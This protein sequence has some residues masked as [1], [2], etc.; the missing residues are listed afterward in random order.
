MKKQILVFGLI[1][2]WCLFTSHADLTNGAVGSA[3]SV[4]CG[5][6][7]AEGELLVKFKG[8][9]KGDGAK[10][11]KEEFKHTVKRDLMHVG[12]S[13]VK[14]PAGITV[15]VALPK[16]KKHP[17]VLG[18]EANIILR[19]CGPVVPN[20]PMY[21]QQWGL[22]AICA[23]YAWEVATGSTN[24]VVAV[25]DSGINYNHEDLAANMWR[26][27]WEIPGNGI[28][29][30]GNGH[31][32][33]VYGVDFVNDDGDPMDE[34][35]SEGIYHGTGIA[36]II[37]AVGQ[38]GIG[39]C[40]LNWDVRLMA[41]RFIRT[42]GLGEAY[43]VASS[44]DYIVEMKQR[45]VNVKAVNMSFG[46]TSSSCGILYPNCLIDGI[47]AL[48]A[49]GIIAV[50]G[51]GN[52]SVDVEQ[53][54]FYP[55]CYGHPNIISVAASTGY[56]ALADFSNWGVVSVDLAAPGTGILMASGPGPTDYRQSSGTSYATPYVAGTVALLAAAYPEATVAQ[57]KAGI[58]DSVDVLSALQG[59]VLTGGQ[60]NIG[61]A[62]LNLK[63]NQAPVLVLQPQNMTV[64]PGGNVMVRASFGGTP[65][66]RYQWYQGDSALA[67]PTNTLLTLTN[68]T[69]EL[70][71]RVQATNAFGQEDSSPVGIGL[72]GVRVP[73]VAWGANNYGQCDV[74]WDLTNVAA[75]AGGRWHSLALRTD[76]TL[77][78]WGGNEYGE[79]DVPTGLSNIVAM[80]AGAYHN[81][82]LGTNGTVAAWGDNY[83]GQVDVPTNLTDVVAVS[84]GQYHNL[85]MKQNGEVV[86]WGL[87]DSSQS[88]VPSGLTN[89]Q[90]V[91]AGYSHS[92]ALLSNGTVVAWGLDRG[93]EV[94]PSGLEGI[95]SVVA[96]TAAS[97]ALKS[98]GT[99]AVWGAND[100][101]QLNVPAGLSNVVAIAGYSTFVA[102]KEDG[103][104][105][106]WGAGMT[107]LGSGQDWGQGIVPSSLRNVNS[108]A[109]NGRHCMALVRTGPVILCVSNK[110]VYEGTAWEFDPPTAF[111][112]CTGSSLPVTILST[113]TNGVSSQIITRTWVATNQCNALFATCSQSVTVLGLAPA[114]TAQPQSQT[115][116]VGQDAP[117]LVTATGWPPLSFQWWF[118]GSTIADATDR[119]Y[120]RTSAQVTDAG[121]YF[122]VVTNSY[123][124]ITSA[125][126]VLAISTAVFAPAIATQPQSQTVEV[127]QDAPFSVTATGLGPLSFQ[128]RFNG[129]AIAG[130]TASAYTRTNAQPAD[131]GT[132]LVVVTN[133]YGGATSAPATLTVV[134]G[135]ALSF[136]GGDRVIINNAPAL[137]PA[138][139]TV[140]TWV[141]FG[142]LVTGS[143][144]FLLCK[145]GD[146]TSG[147]YRLWQGES[148]I[149]FSIGEFWNG[150]G[151]SRSVALI[152]NRWY[153]MAGSYDGAMM[154]LYLDGTLISSN[155]VGSISVGNDSPLYLSFDDVLGYPYSLLGKMDEVRIWDYARTENEIRSTM[156][157]SLAGNEPGL[158]GYWNFNEPLSSQVVLDRST[159]GSSGQL[160]STMAVDGDDPTR[161]MQDIFAP[162]VVVDFLAGPT[163]G[164]APL[165]V[166]FT[167]LCSGATNYEWD[168][169]DGNASTNEHPINLYTNAD[170]Y[171]V[172]LTAIGSGGTNSL[173][174]SDYIVVLEPQLPVINSAWWDYANLMVFWGTGGYPGS[175]YCV[176]AS[177]NVA[178]PMTNWLPVMTNTFEVDGSFRVTNAVDTNQPAQFFRVR[179]P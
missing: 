36:S 157:G 119:A 127:G 83:Y 7:Y 112:G 132:Y 120:T 11:V 32:D 80:S 23:P 22:A 90:A 70:W 140:E 28:D 74:P 48:G 162:A 1:A 39:V 134:S 100:Y 156:Y 163:N 75:V 99:V 164:L 9:P 88:T 18:A 57:L 126:A 8:G 155:M 161:V 72:Q 66:L 111:D 93:A 76:G 43:D 109:I 106:A 81:L 17:D 52:S 35:V 165:T 20:D 42:D 101:G 71:V 50:A 12:W 46:S 117:F 135:W 16:Y 138:Q 142:A 64:L 176:L 73:V 167:N 95:V 146:R 2:C 14:L 123:G 98:D 49:V 67:G 62:L 13:K 107:N 86:A 128:W 168:F 92:L 31:V 102:L 110:A 30:D 47:N 147:A 68:V 84:A 25:I 53:T 104:V 166:Y 63:S 116:E 105:V 45:G 29:D 178:E 171:T 173:T 133:S 149:V 158:V 153:H 150:W 124:G 108:I 118:N 94:V 27:P 60:L 177:T 10:R 69:A 159:N 170:S 40:G 89:V 38:N 129:E 96:G 141:N 6:P 33:D 115:V 154:A 77:S 55:T 169:G 131:V 82:A 3:F 78:V 122:V 79:G 91:S 179:A 172:R 121:S 15:E 143:A 113:V 34:G 114:I 41:F 19:T 65:E 148:A 54:P 59:K 97:M 136:D 44:M 144:Q 160:G 21:P 85:A 174:R 61:R 103:T 137:N 51:A 87:N 56:D 5:Q 58:L 175:S 24:V 4:A 151:T 125:P 130:A 37:G 26:N 145:G 152:T 139:I